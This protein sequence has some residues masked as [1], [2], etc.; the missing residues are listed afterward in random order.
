MDF[1][2]IGSGKGLGGTSAGHMEH[3]KRSMVGSAVCGFHFSGRR[4]KNENGVP[5][6]G[7]IGESITKTNA[8]PNWLVVSGCLV[9]FLAPAVGCCMDCSVL[10]KSQAKQGKQGGW[11][12]RSGRA[13]APARAQGH[14]GLS[15]AHHASVYSDA[16]ACVA[17]P[18]GGGSTLV[19]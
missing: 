17:P 5:R 18:H 4:M 11:A 7:I 16:D 13:G 14:Q 15:C 9:P 6:T 10:C 1:Q 12:A 2:G 8:C 19:P 3:P